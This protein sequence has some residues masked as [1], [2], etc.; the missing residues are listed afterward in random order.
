MTNIDLTNCEL[1][2]DELDAIAAGG[3]LG[4]LMNAIKHDVS[5]LFNAV[6]HPVKTA[7]RSTIDFVRNPTRLPGLPF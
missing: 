1:S 5:V 6:A 7:E 2:I 4:D 3:F